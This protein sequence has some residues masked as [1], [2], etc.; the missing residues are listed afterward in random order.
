VGRSEDMNCIAP[1][2]IHLSVGI[3]LEIL[4]IGIKLN[5][6]KKRSNSA[7][8]TSRLVC[9]CEDVGFGRRNTVIYFYL[10]LYVCVSAKICLWTGGA[11]SCLAHILDLR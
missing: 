2:A 3:R 4:A 10:C 8:V 6:T 7:A 11:G 1:F 9:F 5:H